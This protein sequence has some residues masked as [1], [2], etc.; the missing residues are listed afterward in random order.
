M[1]VGWLGLGAMWAP[2]AA[3]AARAGHVVR[4]YDVVPGRAASLTGD[5]VRPADTVAAAVGGADLTVIMVAATGQLGEAL[6]A[7]AGAA[8]S[9][10]AGSM[11]VV[12][13]RSGPRR[14][15]PPRTALPRAAWPWSTPRCPGGTA[16]AAS[17]DLVPAENLIHAGRALCLGEGRRCAC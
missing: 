5:G 13:R 4:G 14:S 2:M 15:S 16:R 8:G 10:V 7:P 12:R 11:V 1:Q 17:G 3:Q 6:F 9:L